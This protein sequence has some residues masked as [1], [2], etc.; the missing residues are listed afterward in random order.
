MIENFQ[1]IIGAKINDF[2]RKM[3]QVDKKVRETA[4]EATK[5]I[6]AD[7]KEFQRKMAKI[8]AQTK[9][10]TKRSDKTI[11]ADISR[12]LRKAAEVAVVARALTR[13]KVIVPIQA[14][15]KNYQNVMGRIASFN[16]AMG[17]IM[18]MTAQGIRISLSPAIVPIIASLVGLL[19]QLGPM[20]G[21]IG[22][23]AFALGTAFATAGIGAAAFGAI[24]VT[25]L[26]DVFGASSDLKKLQEKL[27]DTT[28]IKERAKILE[29]IKNVQGS[30]NSEQ[31]KALSSMNKLKDTWTGIAKGLE[32]K[33]I[34]IFT[35]ALDIFGG[36]LTALTPMF[37]SV[38]DAVGR[39][40]TSLGQSVK[41]ESMVAF[42]DY[43]NKS[44]GP[45]LETISK[46]VGN[47]FKGFFSMM[48][49]FGPLAESTAA[50]FQAMSGRFAEW[51]AGL[52]ESKKFQSFVDY[53]NE[54]MPKVRSI[55]GDAFQGI[56]NTFAAFAPSSADMM[57]SLQ[58]MMGR[59]K[60]WSS[61]LKDNQG[62]QNFVD[63]V[64]ENGPKVVELIG[65]LTTFL[66]NLGVA[67]A[68]M[69]S[70][71]LD[72]INKF[73]E[74][75]SAMMENHP[76]V[77]KIMAA[78]VVLGGA[79]LAA[80]PH[81]VGMIALFGALPGPMALAA[82]KMI[83]TAATFVSKWALIALKA[84]AS[85]VE[86]AA[87]WT[88]A[89]GRAMVASVGKMIA[90]AATFIAKWTLMGVQALI[91][92]AKQAAAWTLATGAAM[93]RSLGLMIA[94]S[95]TFVAK[96]VW[97]AVQS[98]AQ[99]ARMAS[100]WFI[101][102]GPIGWV[103]GAIVALAVLVIANWDK[104]KSKTKEIW[105]NI[106][107]AV[108][109]AWQKVKEKTVEAVIALGKEI[110]KMPGKVLEFKSKMLSAGKDLIMG[111]IDG[112]KGMASDAI[113]AI[114]GV[115]DGVV[116]K[117]KSLL[118]IKSPSR[119]FVAIGEFLGLGM[120]RG[121]T[122]T[123]A[124]NEKAIKGVTAAI[125]AIAKT[126]AAEVAKIDSNAKKERVAI[127]KD[128]ASK[129]QELERKSAQ[130][131]QTILTTAASK[132]RKLT[133]VESQRIQDIKKDLAVNIQKIEVDSEKKIASINAKARAEKV[134]AESNLAKDRLEAIKQFVADKKSTEDLSLVA[135]AK[136]WE[137]SVKLFKGGTKEKIEAQKAYKSA[138]EAVNTEI[139]NI[140]KEHS[141]QMQ[142][143]NDEL[144][145]QVQELTDEYNK[146]FSD[147]V[148]AI[149]SFAG[150]FDEFAAS[151]EKTGHDLLNNLQ[152]QVTGLEDWRKTLDSLWGKIDDQALME[153]LEAMGPKALGE[154]QALNSLSAAELDK[155]SALYKQKT[156]IAVAQATHELAGLKAD[157]ETR[158]T[159][160][161]E[162]ANKELSV[163]EK[164]WVTKIESITKSTDT[165][166]K[167]LKQ[168]GINAG[169]GLLNGLASMESSLVAKATSIAES[170]KRA[171]ASALDIHSPSR[172]MRDMIGKNTMRGV[173]VGMED[174]RSKVM[175]VA[176]ESTEWMK[177][178]LA[179]LQMAPI[180]TQSQMSSLKR[181]IKHELNVDMSV[182]HS[183]GVG[184]IGG[185][186]NQ[187]VHLHSPKQLSP[188]ENAR[189]LAQVGRQQ[190][191]AWNGG[192]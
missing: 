87:A 186:F 102:L 22:G 146:A 12:F 91:Q 77:G 60:E 16:R 81:I 18:Q 26:K 94:T 30:L 23:S 166:L 66:V 90:T 110:A 3:K 117:A 172:W 36:V 161:R 35:Q 167:T 142:K 189:A 182:N 139:T 25:N 88:L 147:R 111:L 119:V 156:A 11:S 126:H 159:E 6:G 28:D 10:V 43:L 14:S 100:A 150:L 24:A 83:T 58:D 42:F 27:D 2:N 76:L 72:M 82:G 78:V 70:F 20:L 192:F 59:F 174:M 125:T 187:E 89:T 113:G 160:M 114:T 47:F 177:P 5:P 39:L 50:G 164:E 45:M 130:S 109:D 140:N 128:G 84:M 86:Q 53:V 155:Y 185:G 107:N 73:L 65:N 108:K 49:A 123:Q 48:E 173:I 85:A 63:Y 127:Q 157:T 175:A 96:W 179:D 133:T 54:N 165:E 17:E 75:S 32:T 190:A 15:W 135:E 154:L 56:I 57:T 64:K 105:T 9:V 148:G 180:D 40:M 124:A 176:K 52:S 144:T 98:L 118:K 33:T 99:A 92:A 168:V 101:A 115:V 44:A 122:A 55:F 153:E 80:L 141:D 67:L 97:M 188:S 131:I 162:V 151:M 132:K 62:F 152:S 134:K 104:I 170:V 93:A 184:G 34:Q 29:K 143:I 171:M 19:G 163:L 31:T 8:Q 74:W 145:K 38:T 21:T 136:V 95:A 121:I 181:Q 129:V 1:A 68:P 169:Q 7:I 37:T 46:S 51:A 61:T 120:A 137:E 13:D 183:G 79:F 191:L 112:I 41:S 158:I 138:V 149:T 178:N 71:M 116:N 106:S 103:T 69:G 4:F